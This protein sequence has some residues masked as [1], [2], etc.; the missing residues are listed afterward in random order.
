MIPRLSDLPP[1]APACEMLEGLS[2][3]CKRPAAILIMTVSCGACRYLALPEKKITLAIFLLAQTNASYFKSINKI[4]AII[5]RRN[6][7]T[8]RS[9][10]A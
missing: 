5:Y 6:I 7:T 3:L 8:R 9:N 1:N 4:V 10:A 2:L